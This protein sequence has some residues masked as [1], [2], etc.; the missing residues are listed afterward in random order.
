[1]QQLSADGAMIPLL[2]GIWAQVRT[3]TIGIVGEQV[4]P[5]GREV[6]AHDISS[7]SRLCRAAD[8]IDWAALPLHQRGTEQAETVVTVT[9]GASWLQW[10]ELRRQVHQ[11]RRQRRERRRVA[12]A[13]QTATDAV[14]PEPPTK[15]LPPE[16]KRVVDR[17]P[18]DEHRWKQG[19]DQR[20]LAKAR[21]RAKS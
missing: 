2:H 10:Q 14:M 9:D 13:E 19:Y 6:H 1:M 21:A 18:T 8:F 15:R 5:K 16:P 17:R 4:G 7:F 11:E 20:L 3:V 12:R